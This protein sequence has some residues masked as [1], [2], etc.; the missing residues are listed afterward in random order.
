MERWVQTCR[1]ELLDRRL[2]WNQ[3][4]LLYA[5]R[6]FEQLCGECLSRRT[7]QAAAPLRSLPGPVADPGRIAPLDVRRLDRL[8]GIVH[9]YR[10]AA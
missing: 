3:R 10:H 6:E 9:E 5:L 2:I 8:G 7:F 4:R 1:H